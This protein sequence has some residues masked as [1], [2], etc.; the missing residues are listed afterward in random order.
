M[1]PV[2]FFTI[3]GLRFEYL[4]IAATGSGGPDIV[5]LHEGLGCVAQW[6]DFPAQLA[7]ASGCRVIAYSRL[8]HGRSSPP[9]AGR[10]ADYHFEEARRW[11]PRL[12]EHWGIHR[13]LLFGH[14]DGAT[15][16]LV[17]AALHPAEVAAVVAIAPH[18]KVEGITLDGLAR[19]RTAYETSGLRAKLAAY[20][21]DVDSV[22]WSWNRTWL[23][24]AFRDWNIE[25]LLP[26]I[27][28]PVLA[29]QGELDEYATLDQ[30]NSIGRAVQ[31]AELVALADCR[32]APHR[33]QPLRVLQATTR[34]LARLPQ[35]H[36]DG[37]PARIPG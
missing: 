8:G 24:P 15:M 7:Q 2:E 22:F 29:I 35:L 28:A 37:A 9:P 36:G 33:E 23:D 14:S 21:D 1:S 30:I 32:H 4:R 25:A 12:L 19:A 26:A 3:E 13:P 31:D 10:G 18:V 6:R 16:A 17:F 5:M 27:R 34:L 20:H 11:L